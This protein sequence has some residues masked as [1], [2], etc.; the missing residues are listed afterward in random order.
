MKVKQQ[1]L[2]EQGKPL[3]IQY[4]EQRIY[5]LNKLKEL[6]EASIENN[7][8]VIGN[9]AELHTFTFYQD[10]KVFEQDFSTKQLKR[11]Y[12]ESISIVNDSLVVEYRAKQPKEDKLTLVAV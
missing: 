9:S 11:K 1:T 2:H 10:R 3:I 12:V 4:R 7:S 5:V 8:I 6:K